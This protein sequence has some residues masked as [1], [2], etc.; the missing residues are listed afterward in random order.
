MADRWIGHPAAL[1]R[2]MAS[3]FVAR[4]AYQV[5]K[6]PLLPIYAA[7]LGASDLVIGYVVAISTMTGLVLKP[8]VGALSDRT[9]RRLWLILGLVLFAGIPFLYRFVDSAGDL[10][11]LRL[12]H[13][14]ATAVFGPVSLAYVAEMGA[15][16]RGERLGIFGMS[17]SASYLL[18]PLIGAALM[19]VL[20]PEQVFTLIG[21]ASCAAL[22]PALF[23]PET[24]A[25]SPVAR[26]RAVEI[27][28][29]IRDT[30]AFRL[31]AWLEM[32]VYVATYALK[33]F[34]PI[35][36][37]RAME[38][39]LILIGLF[40]TL[41][42]AVHLI[43]RPFAGRWAD[44]A[45]TDTVVLAGFAALTGAFLLL[46]LTE[47]ALT[48]CLAACGIGV[49]LG[50]ILPAT[51]AM[52]TG[53]VR[54]DALGAGMGALGALRNLSKVLGPVLA[55]TLLIWLP[56]QAMFL[57]AAGL[58]GCT[59]VALGLRRRPDRQPQGSS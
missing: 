6:T 35:Y 7:M 8:L 16:R 46:G 19:T 51:L 38:L 25:G 34:L 33:A 52:L 14:T 39:D 18:A 54:A 40:F 28:R 22:I 21:L 49:G 10:Y 53:E 29:S 57:L 37:L 58:L 48:L 3:D 32:V 20:P 4:S 43:V 11:V 5:G 1:W 13:G 50:L 31:V 30:R 42:E 23:L 24:R 41:Q 2:L 44:R 59:A 56:Y 27:M 55:G 26:P 47:G 9:S 36:A 15:A 17:R 45:G 12:L